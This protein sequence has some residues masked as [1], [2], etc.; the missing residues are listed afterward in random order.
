MRYLP[1]VSFLQEYL[2]ANPQLTPKQ[3]RKLK[4]LWKRDDFQR[5]VF[6]ASKRIKTSVSLWKPNPSTDGRPNP[7]QLALESEADELFYGGEAG[8]GKS[9][10]VLG[11]PILRHKRSVVF[12]RTSP[13]LKSI[14]R[15]S[16]EILGHEN[17]NK[18]NKI[19][20]LGNDRFLEFGYMQYEEDKSNWQGSPHDFIGFDEI[21]EFLESQYLFVIGWNRSEDPKQRCRTIVAGNPPVNNDGQWV[22]KAWE[23]WL[24]PDFPEPAE[25]GELR[26]Y[27]YDEDGRLQWKMSDEPVLINGKLERT[28]SRTFIRAGLD[29]NPHLSQ[30]GSY[31]AVLNSLPPVYRAA[32]RDGDFFAVARAKSDPFQ[33]IPTEW[34]RAAQQRW[35]ER[36]KPTGRPTAGGHDV[37]RGGTDQTTYVERWGN[38]FGE[39]HKW[40]GRLVVDGQAAATLVQGVCN[41]PEY[42][43]VDT[44]GYGSSSYDVLKHIYIC[45]E[46]ISSHKSHYRSEDTK[47][48]PYNLRDEMHWRMRE[49]LKPGSG[50]DICLP[51]STELLADLCSA[52]YEIRSG[53]VV[54]VESKE[55]IKKR[56]GRSPDE[57][58][59]VLMAF[60]PEPRRKRVMVMTG[61]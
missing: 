15:R 30:D 8:G 26:W 28:R 29:D 21:P 25:D 23:P 34:V 4:S 6:E 49:A 47:L 20:D 50:Y 61:R 59:C 54:K 9:D 41:N 17:Y 58:D 16:V 56:I 13:N 35:L 57:G 38:Y 3:R 46:F 5:D 33:V 19:H 42:I 14:I 32:F 40:P 37:S 39:I 10:L 45:H 22:I 1:S 48:K 44:I 51:P 2:K 53:G 24:N 43:N 55:D 31:R 7:Q 36:E 12:R 11:C 27:Y 60:M 18:S 52:K